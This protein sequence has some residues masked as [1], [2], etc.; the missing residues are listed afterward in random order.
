MV[1][2]FGGLV[3]SSATYLSKEMKS[4]FSS[5]WAEHKILGNVPVLERT[6]GECATFSLTVTFNRK[7]T[8]TFEAGMALLTTYATSGQYFPLIIGGIPVGGAVAP[9]FVITKA[10]GDYGVVTPSGKVI[11]GSASVEFKQYRVSVPSSAP[12]AGSN[13]LTSPLGGIAAAVSGVA[14]TIGGVVA[15]VNEALGAVGGVVGGISAVSGTVGAVSG[16][17][18]NV[19]GALS[20]ISSAVGG[21]SSLAGSAGSITG[22]INNVG[23]FVQKVSQ[24]VAGGI[25]A[26]QSLANVPA[27]ITGVA[28]TFGSVGGFALAAGSLASTVLPSGIRI[29]KV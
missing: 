6:G 15:T 23:N 10:E 9:N 3:F 29:P 19:G 20:G 17:L 26:V 7:H 27:S 13:S 4:H 8:Q 18:G 1:G 14:S 12:N 28:N 5:E 2:T 11:H 16:V 21:L 25:G 22:V 24:T